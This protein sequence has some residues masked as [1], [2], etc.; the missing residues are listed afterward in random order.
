MS[1]GKNVLIAGFGDIG[2]RLAPLLLKQGAQVT[3]MRRSPMSAPDGVNVLQ[4]DV[5]SSQ[6]LLNVAQEH[7]IQWL[8]LIVTPQAY[9]EAD[10]RG[11]YLAAAQA[12]ATLV[13]QYQGLEHV[14]F[15]SSTSVYAQTQGEWVDE[16]SPTIPQAHSGKVLL[17][18]EQVIE[19][20]GIGCNVRFSGIYGP[21][22]NRL[23]QQVK[24]GKGSAHKPVQFTNRIHADD[25]ARVL[26]HVY[27]MAESGQPLARCY[28]AS[29]SAPV[30][31]ADV[32]HW[33]AQRLN[34]PRDH[35]QA[36]NVAAGRG[37]KRC[38]N[39]RLLDSGFAFR[40]PSF[41]EGYGEL[42]NES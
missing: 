41:K 15:V 28:L 7:H 35:L 38:S 33:I 6:V 16:S 21:G 42:L 37:S 18:S 25:C 23:I 17:A 2:Q 31:M 22:R 3:A 36:S 13:E 11:T 39:Q 34:L 8:Y 12:V 32:K 9:T 19:Q 27:A 14:V 24:D 40:Y 29:D 4:G 20:T 30:S 1:Q 10:Y 26:A 5:T